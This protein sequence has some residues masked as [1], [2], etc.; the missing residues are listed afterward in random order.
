MDQEASLLS[1]TDRRPLALELLRSA[2]FPRFHAFQKL[3]SPL[4][5]GEMI[6]RITAIPDWAMYA[7]MTF[8]DNMGS[9]TIAPE[10]LFD[11]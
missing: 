6:E 3:V 9:V 10:T 5:C 8:D 11:I 7:A 2:D 4:Y 1:C